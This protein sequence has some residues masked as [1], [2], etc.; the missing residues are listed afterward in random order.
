VEQFT[1]RVWD[2]GGLYSYPDGVVTVTVTE[3]Y[4][5]GPS[6][7]ESIYVA[8]ETDKKSGTLTIPVSWPVGESRIVGI[9]SRGFETGHRQTLPQLPKERRQ[10][11]VQMRGA[12][13]A[14]RKAMSDFF[15]SHRGTEIPFDWVH[16]LTKE[17]IAVR[18]ASAS[19]AAK[20]RSGVGPGAE[21]YRFD[22]IEVFDAGTY[23][24]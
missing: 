13:H 24:A 8:P 20:H 9:L 21:D 10:F 15:L 23:G 12:T 11:A 18:F 3:G 5:P 6:E 19:I 7:Q 16:P 4:P 2:D 14:E 1:Y 17:T 22:L